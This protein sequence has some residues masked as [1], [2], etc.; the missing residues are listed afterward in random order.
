MKKE[1]GSAA[2]HL[3]PI[4]DDG[5]LSW[6]EHT[7]PSSGKKY[8]V[9]KESGATNWEPL[10]AAKSSDL[11]GGWNVHHDS[12]SGRKYY[13]HEASGATQWEHPHEGPK[14][15][16]S[17]DPA[18]P[19]GWN[20]H[21]ESGSGKKYYVH[22]ASGATQWEHPNVDPTE[23]EESEDSSD[24]S[25]EE[26]TNPLYW[27]AGKKKA[28][29][30]KQV[31]KEQLA[32]RMALFK[33]R[34]QRNLTKAKAI[35][36]LNKS[37][38]KDIFHGVDKVSISRSSAAFKRRKIGRIRTHNHDLFHDEP[39]FIALS[40]S[41]PGA[42]TLEPSGT[43]KEG[44]KLPTLYMDEESMYSFFTSLFKFVGTVFELLQGQM[45]LTICNVVGANMTAIFFEYLFPVE[46][47][48]VWFGGFAK[49]LA[50][51]LAFRVNQA[52]L[53]FESGK[54]S[55]DDIFGAAREIAVQVNLPTEVEEVPLAPVN[56]ATKEVM[57]LVNLQFGLMRQA[58]REA[59]DGFQPGS[60]LGAEAFADAWHKDPVEPRLSNLMTAREFE[61]LKSM[62]PQVRPT[63]VQCRLYAVAHYLSGF[64]E[65]P[66]L[67]MS[68]FIRAEMR[69]MNAFKSCIRIMETPVPMPYRHLIGLLSVIFVYALP[70][71]MA[72]RNQQRYFFSNDRI[73]SK[74]FAGWIEALLV[75]I[76][77][78]GVIVLAAQFQNPFGYDRLDLDLSRYGKMVH[79]ET[80]ALTNLG[81]RAAPPPGE[82]SRYPEGV[83]LSFRTPPGGAE[84]RRSS[85]SAANTEVDID[86]RER[87][88]DDGGGGGQQ[89]AGRASAG[90]DAG[91]EP[92]QPQSASSAGDDGTQKP[93]GA[94][95]LSWRRASA[96]GDS[97]AGQP[98]SASSTGD[99]DARRT[100]RASLLPWR[101]ASAAGQSESA[102][103]GNDVE[104][105]LPS[106][107]SDEWWEDDETEDFQGRLEAFYRLHAKDKLD[108]VPGL[109]EKFQ[110]R[111]E[112]LFKVLEMKYR[113]Q[114]AAAIAAAAATGEQGS[115]GADETKD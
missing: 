87:S 85:C 72:A 37:I 79:D 46:V 53:A 9:H 16:A 71:L 70:W 60:S 110:G 78:M 104:D 103:A 17:A 15:G 47:S 101:R 64:H 55:L 43:A 12:G 25:I 20:V 91:G 42:K 2:A 80:M 19:A 105:D 23:G 97:A 74:I 10:S 115:G 102:S 28:H 75:T 65:V 58:L 84:D 95:R 26:E 38:D 93:K 13:V 4:L 34:G 52:Y 45:L 41:D 40:H 96:S 33:A 8:Y 3:N 57:R 6:D 68:V 56:D 1:G 99:D 30:E 35:R 88:D 90:G 51:L 59:N 106:D 73:L 21:H 111:E 39:T 62:P 77:Y 31:Q 69:I 109:L 92:R 22:E 81:S 89:P 5:I 27:S 18:V 66:S 113:P 32:E 83:D 54:V 94:S 100:K 98:A 50:F 7:D 48:A 24:E 76:G 44:E 29:E 63:F 86:A 114:D 67:Y 14:G 108:Q 112:Q 49:V 11:P 36:S 82:P 107:S 61:I